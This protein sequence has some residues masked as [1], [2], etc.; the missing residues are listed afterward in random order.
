M[1]NFSCLCSACMH[2]YTH[3]NACITSTSLTIIS[4]LTLWLCKTRARIPAPFFQKYNSTALKAG[5]QITQTKPNQKETQ[6]KSSA[7]EENVF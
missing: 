7:I 2:T 1:A 6:F 5:Q 3:K 4:Y